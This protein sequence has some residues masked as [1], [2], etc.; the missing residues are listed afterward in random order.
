MPKK[1]DRQDRDP[2]ITH[3]IE[4]RDMGLTDT[5]KWPGYFM[6]RFGLTYKQVDEVA[7]HMARYVEVG[8]YARPKKVKREVKHERD[9]ND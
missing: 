3:A 6:R 2:H 7:D 1:F 9:S 4:L 8:K 5:A